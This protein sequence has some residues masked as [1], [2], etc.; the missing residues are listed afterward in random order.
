[1]PHTRVDARWP[2]AVAG[3]CNAFRQ[4]RWSRF[5]SQES[6]ARLDG[7][8]NC[9]RGPGC[10]PGGARGR[11][12]A[13][14]AGRHTGPS[15][16]RRCPF[17]PTAG[18]RNCR[19]RRG[20]H[21]MCQ[22]HTAQCC[23][24]GGLKVPACLTCC[25]LGVPLHVS[26][27]IWKV[28]QTVLA[29]CFGHARCAC[30]MPCRTRTCSSRHTTTCQH[31]RTSSHAGR[32]AVRGEGW[33]GAGTAVGGWRLGTSATRQRPGGILSRAARRSLHPGRPNQVLPGKHGVCL[34]TRSPV[35]VGHCT[36]SVASVAS[37]MYNL[38]H[39]PHHNTRARTPTPAR[40]PPQA[41]PVRQ[42]CT[43]FRG[44]APA[45]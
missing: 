6:N 23:A 3:A 8:T 5:R 4:E 36:G 34:A 12:A 26:T 41:Q 16:W 10:G 9:F 21:T 44:F 43:P 37:Q 28:L 22:A 35:A 2:T 45:S 13:C 1:M 39:M 30:A 25:P 14:A 19:T 31:R 17:T 15:A 42:L 38:M 24:M 20:R 40:Q 33:V 11:V 32:A 7:A 18:G 29:P 27:T